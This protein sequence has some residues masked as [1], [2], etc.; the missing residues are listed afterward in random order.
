MMLLLLL[1]QT[2]K[3]MNEERERERHTGLIVGAKKFTLTKFVI[4]T[5][6]PER[7]LLC[8]IN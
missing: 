5:I 7:I 4:K 6:D 1:K 3:L 8:E 2:D